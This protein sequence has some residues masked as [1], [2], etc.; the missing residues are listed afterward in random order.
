MG[1]ALGISALVLFW[2][3]SNQ[4]SPGPCATLFEY[5][6]TSR[7]KQNTETQGLSGELVAKAKLRWSPVASLNGAILY[8]VTTRALSLQGY[9]E[10]MLSLIPAIEAVTYFVQVSNQKPFAFWGAGSKPPVIATNLVKYFIESLS[11][12][13]TSGVVTENDGFG[14]V[15]VSYEA[16]GNEVSKRKLQYNKMHHP[17]SIPRIVSSLVTLHWGDEILPL[18]A[19]SN[20]K[21]T[22]QWDPARGPAEF[23][24]EV[25]FLA[26]PPLLLPE[27]E[28]IRCETAHIDQFLIDH[29]LISVSPAFE[30][31]AAV[32]Q[33][34][35][36]K[37]TADLLAEISK[38]ADPLKTLEELTGRLEQ[39]PKEVELVRLALEKLINQEERSAFLI[40]ALAN[41]EIAEA[42][43]ALRQL[44]DF[45]LNSRKERLA[46]RTMRAQQL[47]DFVDKETVENLVRISEDHTNSGR[48]KQAALF[49]SA[50]AAT[51]LKDEG[52]RDTLRRKWEE[53]IPQAKSEKE[54]GELLSALGN[55]A[56]ADSTPFLGELARS[57]KGYLGDQALDALRLIRT[58]ESEKVLLAVGTQDGSANRRR[59][60]LHALEFRPFSEA[61]CQKLL[62]RYQSLLQQY[63]TSHVSERMQ[64]LSALGQQEHKDYPSIMEFFKTLE[65]D[66]RLTKREKE[67]VVQLRTTG[68]EATTP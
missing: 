65:K 62:P 3:R 11:F 45:Y 9:P 16:K 13:R 22:Q 56:S 68:F 53:K 15:Q 58:P 32:A 8:Q 61:A 6:V 64:I 26:A 54:K 60:A 66:N 7:Q 21:F 48:I 5:D 41:A 23:T 4:L 40:S 30:F 63:G 47:S 35:V 57:D 19:D 33:K 1:A 12:K 55:L 24:N 59:T 25:S 52:L 34:G 2:F 28:K 17:S 67:Y 18:K 39:N 36:T 44:I 10:G 20:F 49:A 38:Q 50:G 51:V 29:H 42:Q 14:E 37:S 31:D 27:D 43:A 46:I